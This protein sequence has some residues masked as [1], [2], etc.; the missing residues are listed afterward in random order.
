[1]LIWAEPEGMVSG[2]FDDPLVLAIADDRV[3]ISVA[4]LRM[5][6]LP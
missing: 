3:R 5:L 1:M 4:S 6:P 2:I